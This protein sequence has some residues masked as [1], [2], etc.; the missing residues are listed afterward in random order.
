[1]RALLCA[2]AL[3]AGCGTNRPEIPPEL[4]APSESCGDADYPNGPFGTEPGDVAEDACFEGFRTPDTT[5]LREDRLEQLALSD[6]YDAAGENY[7]LILLNTA[8]L[9]C[10]ACQV[11]HQTLPARAAEFEADGLVVL[12]AL[13][14]DEAGA[15]ADFD[16]LRVW[17][18]TFDVT[19]PMA[20]DP[21]YQLG[22]YASADTAPLNLL[23][24]ARN[25]QIIEKFVG[26]QEAVLWP[27]IEEELAARR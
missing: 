19:F 11:E 10:M 16:D 7:E 18:S 8:A 25:L 2:L 14:Q 20:L 15:P 3:V 9:W 26:N 21:D 24:D 17:I 5:A 13:F 27:R 4:L 12:S 1:M 22:V 6:Y 23:I